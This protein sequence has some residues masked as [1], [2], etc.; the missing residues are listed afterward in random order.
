MKLTTPYVPSVVLRKNKTGSYKMR[1]SINI[2][3]KFNIRRVEL[4]LGNMNCRDIESLS[5]IVC[6]IFIFI[7][8]CKNKGLRLFHN[9]PRRQF[10]HL[11]TELPPNHTDY[12]TK[13]NLEKILL[14][15]DHNEINNIF[16]IKNE[17]TYLFPFFMNTISL[18]SLALIVIDIQ[19]KQ[20]HEAEYYA[21][22]ILSIVKKAATYTSPILRAMHLRIVEDHYLQSINYK[23]IS[24]NEP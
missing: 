20:T 2:G 4:G 11:K 17:N 12:I 6:K 19:K 8:L 21:R 7:G 5:I 10:H 22:K 3:K 9:K 23:L 13:N 15:F 18:N 16:L 1:I 24:L 14:Y